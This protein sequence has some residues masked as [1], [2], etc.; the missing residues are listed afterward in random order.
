VTN[1]GVLRGWR[2]ASTFDPFYC[3]HRHTDPS[4]SPARSIR[5]PSVVHLG[6]R[7]TGPPSASLEV[8][9]PTAYSS[10][11]ALS[12][13]ASTRTIPLRSFGCSRRAHH[14]FDRPARLLI[15]A[16]AVFRLVLA[17]R[18][19]RDSFSSTA[20]SGSCIAVALSQAMFRYP[21]PRLRGLVD[22]AALAIRLRSTTLLGFTLRSFD[23]AC[24]SEP[25]LH[26]HAPTCRFTRR[27]PRRFE[28]RDQPSI[29]TISFLLPPT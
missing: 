23:P 1:S 28:S 7:P 13:A 26:G 10:H 14:A 16:P 12:G 17:S 20:R 4:A 9:S 25:C 15:R 3:A 8:L 6:V 2:C 5:P 19:H 18:I 29:S 27:P 24:G 22:P 11:A 21:R